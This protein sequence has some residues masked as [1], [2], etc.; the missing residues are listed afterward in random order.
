MVMF[1]STRRTTLLAGNWEC[2]GE[3]TLHSSDWYQIC[4]LQWWQNG[5]IRPPLLLGFIVPQCQD[6]CFSTKSAFPLSDPLATYFSLEAGLLNPRSKACLMFCTN[7]HSKYGVMFT[8]LSEKRHS[9]PFPLYTCEV[10]KVNTETPEFE[11][12][13]ILRRLEVVAPSSPKHAQCTMPQR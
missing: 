3:E 7:L 8:F 11:L 4:V 1:K 6:F 10:N 5:C 12:L 13:F 2:W 9:P